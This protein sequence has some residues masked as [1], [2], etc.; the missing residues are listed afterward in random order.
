MF[1]ISNFTDNDD[2]TVLKEFG[3][4]KTIEWKRDLSVNEA[5][6]M[7]AYFASEMNVRRRQ[8][9]CDLSQAPIT[10][11]AGA[12]QWMVGNVTCTTGVKGVGDLFGKALRGA[13]TSESA[14][15][16][17]Y[18]GTGL[19]VLE[20]TYRYIITLDVADWGNSIVLDDGLFLACYSSLQHKGYAQ[21][22]FFRRCWQR[23]AVQP[24][25]PGLRRAMLGIP[26]PRRRAD[27]GH[28]GQ[29][30]TQDRR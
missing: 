5:S 10:V 20:P 9:I 30:R 21:Q 8:V 15:K 28:P 6:A 22:R 11:Q 26:L 23:R 16:P 25:H 1:K 18:Q 2:V 27:R 24:G 12:M 29:R 7:N 14:I 17:E 19:L 3:A 4:F 13:V